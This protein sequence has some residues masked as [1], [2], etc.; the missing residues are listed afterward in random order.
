MAPL[1]RNI[2]FTSTPVKRAGHPNVEIV[3][4][5]IWR[6]DVLHVWIADDARLDDSGGFCR[7]VA[8]LG[9]L[10]PQHRY[11]FTSCAKSTSPPNA[12][13]TAYR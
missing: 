5:R 2:R 3:S 6:A 12:V 7:A 8:A 13:S 9:A 4:L 10:W 1:S 11:S